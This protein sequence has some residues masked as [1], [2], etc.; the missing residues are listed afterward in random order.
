M[1]NFFEWCLFAFGILLSA[2]LS[3]SISS[4]FDLGGAG[5]FVLGVIGGVF[6]PIGIVNFSRWVK[7]NV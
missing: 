7:K 3:H 2:F 6:I 1:F 4:H 5:S